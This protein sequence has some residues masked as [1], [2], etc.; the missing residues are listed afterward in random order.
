MECRCKWCDGRCRPEYMPVLVGADRSHVDPLYGVEHSGNT[1]GSD[2]LI[3]LDGAIIEELNFN[4]TQGALRD[5]F[6]ANTSV[7]RFWRLYLRNVAGFLLHKTDKATYGD[8]WRVVLAEN[9]DV[10]RQIG[11]QPNSVEMGFAA[12]TIRSLSPATRRRLAVIG[13]GRHARRNATVS[14]RF[15]AQVQQ[16][17]DHVHDGPWQRH[18]SSA[19]DYSSDH[20]RDDCQSR[21]EQG[22]REEVSVWARAAACVRIERRLRDWNIHRVSGSRKTT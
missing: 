19:R 10:L 3:I 16:L 6:A 13:H 4:Y 7:G 1:P 21:L 15:S 9:E 18:L 12:A 11:W 14:G 8:T 5:G 17:A 22:G 20:R 2:T